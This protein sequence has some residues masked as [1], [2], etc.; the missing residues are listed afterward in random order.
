MTIS[1]DLDDT[2]IP[3]MKKFPTESRTL[4]QRLSGAE[5]LRLG[6]G[7]LW[8]TLQSEGHR[9][10]IYTTSLRSRRKIW[11]TFFTHG[12][13][14][15]RI[16]NQKTHVRRLGKNSGLYSKYPPAFG[17]D[18]HID[19]S[20]GVAREGLQHGFPVIVVSEQEKDWAGYIQKA[21]QALR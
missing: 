12:I 10:V 20:E 6:T 8:R 14:L 2:L 3:G 13:I 15:Y 9:I 1:F 4:L 17:I 18:V 19:D 7:A 16:I 11:W 5:P 21:L